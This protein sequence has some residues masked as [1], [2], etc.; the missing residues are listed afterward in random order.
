MDRC[1]P[2]SIRKPIDTFKQG[3]IMKVQAYI[4]FAGRCERHW[5]SSFGMLTDKYG[6]PWMVNVEMPKT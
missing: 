2:V 5:R 6:V 4:T 3:T 1:H